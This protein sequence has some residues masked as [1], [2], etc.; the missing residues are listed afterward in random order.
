MQQKIKGTNVN[1]D[2]KLSKL[3]LK[4]NNLL[5]NSKFPTQRAVLADVKL[6]SIFVASMNLN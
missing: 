5:H 3:T 1:F 2:I 6:Q 4:T